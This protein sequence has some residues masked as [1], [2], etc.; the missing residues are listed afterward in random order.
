MLER[1]ESK[2]HGRWLTSR[3][4]RQTSGNYSSRVTT[5]NND[6][7]IACL[8]LTSVDDLGVRVLEVSTLGNS[9]QKDDGGG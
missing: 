9:A 3:V 6:V 8:D 7:V 5:A 1:S 2:V 4:F